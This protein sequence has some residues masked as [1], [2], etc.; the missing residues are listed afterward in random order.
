MS[1]LLYAAK[2]LRN[3]VCGRRGPLPEAVLLQ[4][5]GLVPGKLTALAEEVNRRL[6]AISSLLEHTETDCTAHFS[7]PG[8]NW[9]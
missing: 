7:F 2:W 9:S 4:P 3:A 5:I 6:T 1:V 8:R